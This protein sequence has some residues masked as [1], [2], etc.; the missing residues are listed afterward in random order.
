MTTEIWHFKL[1]DVMKYWFM[2]FFWDYTLQHRGSQCTYS[3]YECT[4]K[5]YLYEHLRRL[6]QQIQT[7]FVHLFNMS[8]SSLCF[9]V[10]CPL[11]VSLKFECYWCWCWFV[12]REKHC[13]NRDDVFSVRYVVWKK[14]HPCWYNIFPTQQISINN[15]QIYTPRSTGLLAFCQ[16]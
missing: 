5:I 1:L 10:H 3:L 12:V 11:F 4:H 14:H 9:V 2:F 7:C 16:E 8:S 6:D 15:T 13:T